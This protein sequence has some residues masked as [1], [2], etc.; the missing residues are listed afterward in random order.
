LAVRGW[1]F[2][3][4]GAL[5]SK[6][7]HEK[8]NR[9][10][11]SDSCAES[12]EE[13]IRKIDE[14]TKDPEKL[15]KARVSPAWTRSS[16]IGRSA[17]ADLDRLCKL[18]A[19]QKRVLV[20]RALVAWERS[21]ET[22]GEEIVAQNDIDEAL[23]NNRPNE[24]SLETTRSYHGKRSRR[25]ASS[26]LHSG[27]MV[28]LTPVRPLSCIWMRQSGQTSFLPSPAVAELRPAGSLPS[29]ILRNGNKSQYSLPKSGRRERKA[30]DGRRRGSPPARPG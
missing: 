13:A 19:G 25:S 2:S 30:G 22:F 11:L 17:S 14:R 8:K 1:R 6:V 21:P 26:R 7:T 23:R 16:R 28:L 10:P 18:P 24:T 20:H 5:W 12:D 15:R 29:P 9:V 3:S 4:G 27:C